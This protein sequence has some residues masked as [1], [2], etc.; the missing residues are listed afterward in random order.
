MHS[1]ISDWGSFM[2]MIS[3]PLRRSERLGINIMFCVY[4]FCV[5]ENGASVE[6]DNGARLQEASN[7]PS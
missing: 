5:V 7:F 6:R 3:I 1:I 2:L 4:F